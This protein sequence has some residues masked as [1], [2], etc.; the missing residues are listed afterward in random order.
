MI[1]WIYISTIVLVSLYGMVMLIPAF[2]FHF[3][4]NKSGKN[5]EITAPSSKTFISILLPVRNEA[6]FIL[7]CLKSLIEQDYPTDKF[8]II[9]INDHSTD[10]TKEIA[11][12]F[13]KDFPHLRVIDNP[14]N[15]KGKKSAITL[16]V[17]VAKGELIATTDGDCIVP[18]KWLQKIAT[19]FEQQQALFIAGPVSYKKRS[20]ILRPLLQIEQIV[21][22]IISGGAMR[23]G[24]PMMCSG[25]NL[26]Y[27]KDFFIESG[28]YEND[29]F[30]SGDDMMMLLLAQKKIPERLFFLAD[31]DAIVVTHAAAN[32]SEAIQQRSRWISKFSTYKT[33]WITGTGILVFLVN[34]F[35]VFL[36]LIS[37]WK[38]G[39]VEYFILAFGLKMLIDLLLLSLAVPFFREPRLYLLALL[40]E[41]FYP[42]LAIFVAIAR[43]S[44]SFH[45]KGRNWKT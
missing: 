31:R 13:A 25:A 12:L 22:Q 44:G 16:G 3:S 39:F 32:F 34:I 29:L 1:Y 8:E 6:H 9:L 23:I 36:G 7:D 11:E 28:G 35:I 38:L 26:A 20:G 33:V 10:R 19:A 27:K 15:C 24:F 21:L 17:Q 30:A 5:S 2:A 4:K 43:L 42:F 37:L 18:S 41:L 40:E 45:W 14:P